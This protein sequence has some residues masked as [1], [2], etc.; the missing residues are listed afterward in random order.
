MTE[1]GLDQ[2]PTREEA[3]SVIEGV[4]GETPPE[5]EEKPSA[6]AEEPK[7]PETE[8]PSGEEPKPE[9]TEPGA[10][11]APQDAAYLDV[12]GRRYTAEDI[13]KLEEGNLRQEDYSRN[14]TAIQEEKQWLEERKSYL[15]DME[16]KYRDKGG[17]P[18]NLGAGA[19]GEGDPETAEGR[20]IVKLRQ[21]ISGVKTTLKE[22]QEARA[23][24]DRSEF[25]RSVVNAFDQHL[26][27]LFTRYKV[28]DNPAIRSR[29]RADTLNLDPE[30][31]DPEGKVSQ[32]VLERETGKAFS[33][34]F[35]GH[36]AYEEAVKEGYLKTLKPGSAAAPPTPQGG[37]PTPT[38]AKAKDD[39]VGLEPQKLA[40][41][42]VERVAQLRGE[43]G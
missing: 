9:V 13:E 24:R 2:P 41:R 17:D 5:T 10:E 20:E 12:Q 43:E 37:A 26:G 22:V 8:T 19:P 34:A 40:V 42:L 1:Q 18:D 38:R 23:Q 16:G 30:F 36:T 14:M 27:K 32:R 29:L 21:E 11:G 39:I 7:P 25:D 31:A 4:L 28:P 33:T 3:A 35:K 6:V 15:A